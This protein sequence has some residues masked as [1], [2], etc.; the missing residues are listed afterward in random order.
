MYASQDKEVAAAETYVY[1]QGEFVLALAGTIT[2]G[3]YYLYN[4]N[5]AEPETPDPTP[6]PSPAR[7]LSIIRDNV[8]GMLMLTNEKM[9]ESNNDIWYSIDGR[10]LKGKPTSKGLYI[11]NNQKVVVR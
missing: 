11:R 5:Y 8:T 3:H 7:S 10:R 4:P 6:N 9:K 2:P 1:Y